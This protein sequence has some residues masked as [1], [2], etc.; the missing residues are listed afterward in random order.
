MQL[1]QSNILVRFAPFSFLETQFVLA[2]VPV[3]EPVGT[4]DREENCQAPQNQ[5]AIEPE[6]GLGPVHPTQGCKS[7]SAG[8]SE[9]ARKPRTDI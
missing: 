3:A 9:K 1:P 4:I 5:R 7:H 2:N 8:R 6:K